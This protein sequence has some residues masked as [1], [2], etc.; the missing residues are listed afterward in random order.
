MT[1]VWQLCSKTFYVPGKILRTFQVSNY[2]IFTVTFEVRYSYI[3]SE[4]NKMTRGEV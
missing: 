4:E 3:M 2:L 1:F